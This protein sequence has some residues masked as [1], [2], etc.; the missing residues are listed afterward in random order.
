MP[1]PSR[2]PTAAT[3]CCGLLCLGVAAAVGP[4]WAQEQ[5]PAMPRPQMHGM[6]PAG[7]PQPQFPM[8]PMPGMPFL[9]G[10]PPMPG[11]PGSGHHQPALGIVTAPVGPQLQAQLDL[12]AGM[13]LVVEVVEPAGAA[14]AAGIQRFDIL[15]KFDDQLLCSPEQLQALAK[16]AGK[17]KEVNLTVIRAAQERQV[18]VTLGDSQARAATSVVGGRARAQAHAHAGGGAQAGAHVGGQ[19]GPGGQWQTHHAHHSDRV[20][21][22]SN[23]R[24]T[25]EI[26]E[27]D[28]VRTV[29]VRNAAG[30]DVHAGPLNTEA[31]W[32]AVP[33]DFLEMA[34]AVAGKLGD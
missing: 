11:M 13:G 10:M 32:Q 29:R 24:G 6:P 4:A 18:A 27:T 22:E 5:Q 20:F 9:P 21:S 17:G 26:R 23:E 15:R 30:Q 1:R 2:R 19:A 33:A 34:R 3:Y 14:A 25:V 31:D 16:A 7:Q 28:G 8:P 12:P